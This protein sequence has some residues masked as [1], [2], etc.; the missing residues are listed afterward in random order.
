MKKLF[1]LIPALVF[2]LMVNA[3]E[4]PV[5]SG[6]SNIIHYTIA[7]SNTKDGDVL[8]LTDAGPYIST[9]GEDDYT[10]LV[11]NL[12]IKAADGIKPVVK[13]EVPF[14]SSGGKTVKFIGIT[15]D[16]TSLT[17]Y[18]FYF[19]FYDANDNLEFED[20][21]FKNIS[22]YIF[23]VYT[24]KTANSLKL[25]NCDLH[26]NSSR[27]LLNRGTL[28][29]LEINGGKIYNFTG[30]PVV[31]NYDGATLGDI[32]ING[33]EFYNNA[34]DI[35]SG[36]AT[37]HA[38][39]CIINNCYFHNN[40]RSAVYFAESSVS[41]VETCDGVI[42]KNSTFANNDLSASSRSVIEV[43]NYGGTEAANIEVKV[44][45]CTFYNNTTK[46]FDYSGIRS[47]KSTKVSIT[48]SIF[49]HPSAI[50]F[51][52]TNCYGGTISNTLVYNIS[53]GHRSSGGNPAVSN[54]ITADPLFTDAANGDF[55][56]PNNWV[57]MSLSP[58]CGAATDGSD[59]GAPRWA[60]AETLPSTDFASPYAFVGGKA[61]IA[62]NIWYDGTNDYIYYNDKSENGTATWKINAT[63]ACA[64]GVT[65]N[66]NAETTTGHKFKVV[67]IDAEG[68]SIGEAAEANQS[69]ASGN[70]ELPGSI[71]LP[72]AGNY[73]VKLFNL[74][75]WSS[76]KI[77]SITLSYLGG[78]VQNISA[79]TNTT[80][81]VAD[82]WFSANGT[83]ADGKIT[84]PAGH[85]DEGWVR[86][87]VHV[88]EN[89][90]YDVTVNIVSSNGHNYEVKLFNDDRNISLNEG[91]QT[92]AASP[93]EIG[94]MSIP[95][96]DY[97][98]EITNSVKWSDAQ[99]VSVQFAPVASSSINLPA[100]LNF[101]DAVLGGFAYVEEG[102]LYFAHEG[103]SSEE[104]HL[105]ENSWAAWDVTV[106]ESSTFLFTLNVNSSNGQSYKLS[107]IDGNDNVV[108]FFEKNPGSGAKE[109]KHYF[110]LEAGNYSVKV[111]NT[112]N[113]SHGYLTS[114]VVSQP[115]DI[116]VLSENATDNSA[117]VD[118]VGDDNSYK[119]QIM[120][121]FTGGMYNTICLPIYVSG[122]EAK[123]VFG[124][125]VVLKV[126]D[127]AN[128]DDT[129][130]ILELNFK[131]S[132]DIWQGTP[133]LIKP[134]KNIVNP[135]F[136]NVE[137][138]TAT[139]AATTKDQADFVGTFVATNIPAGEENLFLGRNDLLYFNKSDDTPVGGFR[140]WFVLH[141]IP[142]GPHF[143][144]GARIVE[145]E[146]TATGME[147][148]DQQ[149][150]V[151]TQKLIENGMLII[152]RD[153]I[154]YNVMGVRV[155]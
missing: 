109:L 65:L 129:E 134:S 75:G 118:K 55:T 63:R 151:N 110:Y 126:L 139:P 149:S 50:D 74:T 29:N 130:S 116:I 41:G 51:Y 76:A 4:I 77:N 105:A 46:N 38:D 80:L 114:L 112:T 150:K 2:S 40:S 23:D 54:T 131:S 154:R 96:G 7:D 39:S 11:K 155:E 92:S 95:A 12:T 45:H 83:R 47:R 113:W 132:S 44:D 32:R 146:N 58:A 117:W 49:A 121:S 13:L 91:G 108:D 87:N 64:L 1:L 124:D 152:I 141:D 6:T 148:V 10:K 26:D 34:K 67:I 33:T 90:Y 145:R 98:L 119:V 104:G 17:G 37:S 103:T 69:S 72:A 62:G 128:L 22:K 101:G 138:K 93:L 135:V 111:Q 35:I 52:A 57:T 127:G 107:I 19:R 84:I 137:F 88:T 81:D 27:G 136:E 25:T 60:V 59:L 71:V 30:Y 36:T 153:G 16:G 123:K 86:W 56:F 42:V 53:R 106:S 85:Q 28:N 31:D 115:D 9:A 5:S 143:I 97:T 140:G 133:H 24:G 120:R 68:N 21:E 73:T 99:L 3:D 15:F 14:R 125:D 147:N 20:C 61:V 48:N 102:N 70:I 142:D 94:R 100:T 66:M 79:S 8:V 78:A 18:D 144:R 122:S 43:Q 89:K 82:A